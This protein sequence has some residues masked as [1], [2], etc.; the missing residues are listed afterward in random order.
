MEIGSGYSTQLA[1][2]AA[3]KNGGARVL[4]IEPFPSRVLQQSF[5]K[6]DDLIQS[7]VQDVPLDVFK[8]FD[9]GDV[10]F[11][12][13]SHTVKAGSD[14]N[15][16]VFNILPA[17]RDGVII[18]FHD[19]FLPYEYPK[20]WITEWGFFWN[21][22]YLI[23]AFLMHNNAFT[24][25]LMNYFLSKKFETSLKERLARFDFT[26]LKRNMGGVRGASFWMIKGKEWKL[27][28]PGPPKRAG[29]KISFE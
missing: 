15:H 21:E 18:H 4:G 26:D 28:V 5:H 2:R 14:V 24:P 9:R 12:D 20:H 29:G 22:Q 19:V 7:N 25:L 13:T 1:L 17:L 23:L 16:I 11:V 10:L 8:R 27:T 6:L 3:E